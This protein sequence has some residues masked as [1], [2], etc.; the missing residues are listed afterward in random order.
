MIIAKYIFTLSVD[1][2]WKRMI[3]CE[4]PPHD[5]KTKEWLY[6]L[7]YEIDNV[8][9]RCV[10]VYNEC[11]RLLLELQEEWNNSPDLPIE[12]EK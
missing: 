5:L 7:K 2:E 12:S 11:N 6:H 3:Q 4:M 1:E 8:Y 9:S 10:D